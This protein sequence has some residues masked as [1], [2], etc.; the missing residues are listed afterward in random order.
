[1][2]VWK[3][4]MEAV[5]IEIPGFSWISTQT[6]GRSPGVDVGD[7]F[8]VQA[9]KRMSSDDRTLFRSLFSKRLIFLKIK[10]H[11]WM[12]ARGFRPALRND[13]TLIARI[14]ACKPVTAPVLDLTP[15]AAVP[16]E[17]TADACYPTRGV[18]SIAG[19]RE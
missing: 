7:V 19:V 18:G 11:G 5:A 1:M 14:K 3:A 17:G 9:V 8:S 13:A 6:Y 4:G 2:T 12:D 10:D 15:F 16:G